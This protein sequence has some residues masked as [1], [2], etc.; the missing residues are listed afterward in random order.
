MYGILNKYSEIR[1]FARVSKF[2][3]Q[4]LANL[5]ERI[6]AVIFFYGSSFGE[7]KFVK[8]RDTAHIC[9]TNI[10]LLS[11]V[12]CTP[13]PTCPV[14]EKSPPKRGSKEKIEKLPITQIH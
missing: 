12:D 2:Y 11:T 6:L 4:K 14:L 3:I 9:M 7:I 13:Q 1:F 8:K 10:A 5:Y